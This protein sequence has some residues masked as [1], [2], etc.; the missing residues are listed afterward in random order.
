MKLNYDRISPITGKLS[1]MDEMDDE[2][3]VMSLDM[4]TGY[5][6]YSVWVDGSDEVKRFEDTSP[7]IVTETKFTDPETH[8]VWFKATLFGN[9]R[10]LYPDREKWKVGQFRLIED[11][12]EP[13][14]HWAT[15]KIAEDVF[16]LDD[17]TAKTYDTFEEAFTNYFGE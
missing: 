4:D 15:M 7:P 13:R 1:V 16:T 11:V 8:Q 3:I 2:G 10:V 6:T 14:F 5:Q 9:G 12:S 17:A